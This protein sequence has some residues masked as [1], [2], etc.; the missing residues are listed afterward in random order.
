MYAL[1][2]HPGVELSRLL[3][4]N[5]WNIAQFSKMIGVS[6]SRVSEIISGK[7]RVSIDSAFRLADAFDMTPEY[8]LRKQNEYDIS[9]RNS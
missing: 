8:W 5:G 3:A 4:K 2:E 9:I 6:T 1:P 7:R